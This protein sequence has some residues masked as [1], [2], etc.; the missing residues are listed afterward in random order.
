M[1]RYRKYPQ[2]FV[3]SVFFNQ[4]W[5]WW[6]SLAKILNKDSESNPC[7]GRCTA[8]Y[9]ETQGRTDWYKWRG[10]QLLLANVFNRARIVVPNQV[11]Y[12]FHVSLFIDN[13]ECVNTLWLTDGN[14]CSYFSFTVI[15]LFVL[16]ELRNK[17][18]QLDTYMIHFHLHFIKV[19]RLDKFRALFTHLQETLRER[20]F[21]DYCVRL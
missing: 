8:S 9:G 21:G 17:H 2:V 5:N 6:Q 20:R 12:S 3:W 15:V 10:W 13:N 16:T 7:C 4:N 1:S 19:Q 18:N 14:E 11:L